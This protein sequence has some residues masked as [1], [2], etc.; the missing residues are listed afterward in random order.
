MERN[1]LIRLMVM[2]SVCDDYENVD[3]VILKQ[4][5]PDGARLGVTIQREDV[6]TALAKLIA[7]GLVQAYRLSGTKRP[8]GGFRDLLLSDARRRESPSC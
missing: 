8:G 7:G 5:A 1:E 3:Q 2:N 6:V 4:I